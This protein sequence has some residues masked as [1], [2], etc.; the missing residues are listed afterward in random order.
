MNCILAE[1]VLFSQTDFGHSHVSV[2]CAC[3]WRFIECNFCH[4]HRNPNFH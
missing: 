4:A 3:L 1:T 2:T